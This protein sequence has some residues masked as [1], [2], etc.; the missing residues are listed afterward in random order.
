MAASNF[1]PISLYH[2]T[3]ASA[4]PI[5]GNLISGELAINITDGKLYFKNNAGVVTLLASSGGGGSSL[6]ITKM[7]AQSFGGF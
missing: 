5:A 4:V 2:S 3:T 1:T 7:Q 6:P